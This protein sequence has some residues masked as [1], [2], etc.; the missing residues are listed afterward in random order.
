[1]VDLGGE[2][3]TRTTPA[4]SVGRRSK[5]SKSDRRGLKSQLLVSGRTPASHSVSEP[6]FL[7]L[8]IEPRNILSSRAVK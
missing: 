7:H 5:A 4:P 8:Q 1:M 3:R 2:G 6:G